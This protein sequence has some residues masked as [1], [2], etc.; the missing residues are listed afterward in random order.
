LTSIQCQ[1]IFFQGIIWDKVQT[2]MRREKLRSERAQLYFLL[3]LWNNS[4]MNT[5]IILV[6]LVSVY[7]MCQCFFHHSFTYC[8]SFLYSW[9]SWMSQCSS[10][11]NNQIRDR[12]NL[13]DRIWMCAVLHQDDDDDD[14]GKN[15]VEPG[16]QEHFSG[17]IC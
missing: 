5:D 14:D 2:L 17:K 6:F 9:Y 4:L 1:F 15:T 10:G 7:L 12:S 11:K 13:Q 16:N 8:C 3:F